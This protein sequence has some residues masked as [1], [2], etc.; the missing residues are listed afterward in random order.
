MIDDVYFNFD[1][2]YVESNSEDQLYWVLKPSNDINHPLFPRST[3]H[4]K[5]PFKHHTGV[6]FTDLLKKRMAKSISKVHVWTYAD[7]A[8]P[9]LQMIQATEVFRIVDEFGNPL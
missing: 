7:S 4:Q 9:V 2:G 8:A 5:I 1:Q 3:F 6:T